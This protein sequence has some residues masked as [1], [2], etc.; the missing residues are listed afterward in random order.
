[1]SEP[2][3]ILFVCTGNTCRSPM[4][5]AAL[6]VLLDKDRPGRYR[7]LSAGT[8]AANGFPATLY[9]LEAVKI[10]SGDLSR[11]RSQLL[12]RRLIEDADL[13]LGMTPEHVKEIL[14]LSPE[15]KPKVFLFKNFPDGRL[16][17]EGVED[18]VG[19]SLDRYNA[20][21]LEIGEYLGKFLSEIVKRIDEKAAIDQTT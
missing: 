15:A 12:S 7:V 17:G 6:R 1:M 11:H 4:A 14:R 3:T 10:W 21:F 8:A 19:Q 18:P 2:Y 9:A 20:T 13:V 5:E 16:T